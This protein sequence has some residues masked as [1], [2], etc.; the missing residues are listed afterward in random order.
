MR[1]LGT[2]FPA[3][4]GPAT[5]AAWERGAAYAPTVLDLS[6]TGI[7]TD[8]L[9]VAQQLQADLVQRVTAEFRLK[10]AQEIRLAIAGARTPWQATQAI[11]K[12]LQTQPGRTGMGS[13]AAQ[14]ER[15]TRTEL[16]GVFNLADVAR[17]EQLAETVPTLKKWWDAAQD[18]RTRPTHAA[19]DQ[20]YRPGGSQGPIGLTEDFRVG[21]ERCAGPHDPRLSAGERV[22]CRC[23]RAFWSPDWQT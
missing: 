2:R 15:I 5:R 11:G 16:M 3:I 14:A 6:L 18:S 17:N 10:A 19:A 8:Q 22:N 4:L 9:L 1:Q 12:L 13:I 20:R 7:S 21:G 23:V